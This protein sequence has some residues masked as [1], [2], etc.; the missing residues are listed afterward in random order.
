MTTT[1]R[2]VRTH[3]TPLPPAERA[4]G[5]LIAVG[6]ALAV[7]EV[8]L[9]GIAVAVAFTLGGGGAGAAALVV[10]CTAL[11]MDVAWWMRSGHGLAWWIAGISLLARTDDA[12]LGLAR[13]APMPP[14][15]V[16]ATR[17]RRH[18]VD[19]RLDPIELL[20][21]EPA[22]AARS[23]RGQDDSLSAS[24]APGSDAVAGTQPVGVIPPV[25]PLPPGPHPKG[26]DQSGAPP[27]V[28]AAATGLPV[29]PPGMQGGEPESASR[30]HGGVVRVTVD[31]QSRH[32]LTGTA[33]VGRRPVAEGEGQT[34]ITVTD[35]TRRLSKNHLCLEVAYDGAL[36][37]TDLGSTNGSAIVGP[38][39]SRE[40]LLPHAPAQLELH[41]TVTLGDHQLTFS[42][43]GGS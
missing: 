19:V 27:A 17:G 21:A 41:D 39:G 37:V 34:T 32:V 3:A 42:Q 10:T 38:D 35:L 9:A 12:P 20:E 11:A 5:G 1:A 2:A 13:M 26:Q 18:P 15:W 24:A 36:F 30:A 31:G 14:T 23:S 7:V 6:V 29:L 40:V 33:I 8:M 22:R 43:G 25:P 4:G 28:P 16:A